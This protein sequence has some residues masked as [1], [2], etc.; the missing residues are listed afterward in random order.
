[1]LDS[2]DWVLVDVRMPA[3]F[4]KASIEGAKSAPLFKGTDFSKATPFSMLRAAAY[5]FNGVKP[6]EP[7]ADF[8]ADVKAA[9]GGKGVILVRAF[10]C[11]LC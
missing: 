1:M 2:G 3:D 7:N 9:A 6:V 10:L 11:T 4:E 8:A 5:A